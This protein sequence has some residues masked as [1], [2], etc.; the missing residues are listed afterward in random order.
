MLWE[1]LGT[2]RLLGP[3]TIE[4]CRWVR[5]GKLAHDD[6]QESTPSLPPAYI[7]NISDAS[8]V[9]PQ[10]KWEL[11]KLAKLAKLKSRQL[12]A[13]IVARGGGRFPTLDSP[14]WDR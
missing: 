4:M 5:A 8:V 6:I 14:K 9:W 13:S 11:A 7:E 2:Q 3:K 10:E 12:E 1:R